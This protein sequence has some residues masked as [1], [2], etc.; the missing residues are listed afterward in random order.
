MERAA[1][2]AKDSPEAADSMTNIEGSV[3]AYSGHLQQARAK[4][5]EAMTL[6]EEGHQQEKAA[7]FAAGAAPP[8][9]VHDALVTSGVFSDGTGDIDSLGMSEP[10]VLF[11]LGPIRR[12]RHPLWWWV[13]RGA[14]AQGLRRSNA[15]YSG[16]SR[17]ALRAADFAGSED[18]CLPALQRGQRGYWDIRSRPEQ[19]CAIHVRA[20]FRWVSDLVA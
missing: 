9:C 2:A 3:L 5:R 11:E 19:P 13:S 18:D 14:S 7:Q 12:R 15:E 1:T 20:W 16:G 10:G 6:S 17:S 8:C 4:T